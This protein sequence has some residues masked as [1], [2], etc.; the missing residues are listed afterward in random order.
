MLCF[1]FFKKKEKIEN[2]KK[3]P[4]LHK[5]SHVPLFNQQKESIK[6]GIL[7]LLFFNNNHT[8]LYICK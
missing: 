2:E 6:E 7:N 3:W 4:A 5:Q 8:L 1:S